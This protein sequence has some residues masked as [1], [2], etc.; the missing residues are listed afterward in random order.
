MVKSRSVSYRIFC[1]GGGGEWRQNVLESSDLKHQEGEW[2][3]VIL[4]VAGRSYVVM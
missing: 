1:G 3:I 2:S 4:L